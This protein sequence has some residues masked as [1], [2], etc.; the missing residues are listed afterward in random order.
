VWDG[1]PDPPGVKHRTGA[2]RRAVLDEQVSPLTQSGARSR[3]YRDRLLRERLGTRDPGPTI[4]Y[5]TLQRTAERVAADLV[6]AGHPARAYHAGMESEQRVE[7]QEWWKSSDYNI[8]EY[9]F[10][11][12]LA[13]LEQLAIND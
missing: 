3:A 5:V 6:R 7:V 13:W 8:E 4:V 11:D 2:S 1:F 10:S 9:R 12:V